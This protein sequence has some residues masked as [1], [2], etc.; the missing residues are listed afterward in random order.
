M[1]SPNIEYI[2]GPSQ[3]P[4]PL[5]APS[6]NHY[7]TP[8]TQSDRI[9]AAIAHAS[10]WLNLFTA[11]LGLAV[12]GGI[13]LLYRSRQRWVAGQ[14]LQALFLQFGALALIALTAILAGLGKLTF[15]TIIG[16]LFFPLACVTGFGVLALLAYSI[17]GAV[18]ALAG[19]DFRYPI[20]GVVADD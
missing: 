12:A 4:M 6:S 19:R 1:E 15:W 13:W 17:W 20:I 14:A 7:I 8:L 5:P 3:E 2:S 16:L 9:I 11:F 10:I 18:Q